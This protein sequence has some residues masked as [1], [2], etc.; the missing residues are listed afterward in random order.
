MIFFSAIV[1]LKSIRTFLTVAAYYDYKIWQIDIKTTFLNG[2]LEEDIYMEQPLSFTSDDSDHW[3]YK[4]QKSIYGLKQ[5][6]QSWNF[7]FDDA[8]KS[9][10][11]IKNKKKSYI[12]KRISGS[13]LIFFILYVDDILLIENDIFML[14]SVKAWLFK[15]FS[16][17]DLGEA[18]YILG[19]KI[20][21]DRSRMMLGPS[22]KLYIEKILKWFRMKNSKR[23]SLPLRYGIR[24]SKTI[25]PNTFEEIERMSKIPYASTIESLMYAMLCTR[26]DIVLAVSV[27]SR[28]QSNLDEKH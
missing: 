6:S 26:P 16:M 21:K 2:Y 1:I 23:G 12:Y 19:I 25:Y 17:K 3:I 28:Y 9:F 27:T 10:D 13:A 24:L 7:Y 11:F 20:Y 8:I 5:D 14:T 18:S 22:Q 15:E 4:L